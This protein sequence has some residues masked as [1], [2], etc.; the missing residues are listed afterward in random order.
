MAP[1]TVLAGLLMRGCIVVVAVV[2]FWSSIAD[3]VA[4][5]R[6]VGLASDFRPG[7]SL[8]L[9]DEWVDSALA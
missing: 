4:I 5:G 7:S 6:P 2:I 9:S 8:Y 3:L 1:G